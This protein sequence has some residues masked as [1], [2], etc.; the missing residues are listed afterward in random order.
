MIMSVE[1]VFEIAAQIERNGM[2]FYQ[3]AAGIASAPEI[4]AMLLKFAQMEEKHEKIFLEMKEFFVDKNESQIPDTDSQALSYIRAMA[5][6][7]IFS[8]DNP[9]LLINTNSSIKEIFS[10]AL[11]IE[12][13]SVVYY[14]AIKKLVSSKS[15]KEKIDLLI[16]EELGH[17]AVL[18]R[19]MAALKI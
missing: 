4:K 7:E 9:A 2:D 8:Q 12:K 10:I 18:S 11:K 16:N 14:A 17:I 1:E 6:G 3:K 15:D 13:D 5:D 19:E